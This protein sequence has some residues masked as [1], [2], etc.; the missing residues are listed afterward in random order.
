MAYGYGA[1]GCGPVAPAETRFPFITE[2]GFFIYCLLAL[3]RDK[4]YYHKGNKDNTRNNDDCQ[5][6][7][8]III[9][10]SHQFTPRFWIHIIYPI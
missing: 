2:S 10:C 1:Y 6:M 5:N 8:I 7:F 4:T 3:C 9:F